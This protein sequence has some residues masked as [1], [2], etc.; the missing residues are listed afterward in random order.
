M[1]GCCPLCDT[2]YH[3]CND[4]RKMSRH[5]IYIKHWYKDSKLLVNI[6]ESCH[7]QFNR[8]YNHDLGV[9]RW[10][11]LK[12]LLNWISF[13]AIK[14]KNAYDIWPELIDEVYYYTKNREELLN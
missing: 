11:R 7:R 5:H 3:N 4:G 8:I 12:C 6:C 2:K 13:C 14:N 10:S 1:E 9:I